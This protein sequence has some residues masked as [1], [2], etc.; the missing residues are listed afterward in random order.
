MGEAL[1]AR[2]LEGTVKFGGGNIMMLGCM[3]QD[4]VG[5]ACRID[6]KMNAQLYTHILEEDFQATLEYYGQEVGDITF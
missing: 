3:G 6:G 1:S 5:Y 2:L 4:G